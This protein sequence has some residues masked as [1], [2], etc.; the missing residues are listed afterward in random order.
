MYFIEIHALVFHEI[1]FIFMTNFDEI[2]AKIRKKQLLERLIQLWV[3]F[4]STF[5]DFN[6][7]KV[8]IDK[9]TKLKNKIDDENSFIIENSNTDETK[10]K[11]DINFHWDLKFRQQVN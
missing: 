1:I 5:I 6:Y 8:F 4:T 2:F 3:F 7:E 10:S 11:F 9:A